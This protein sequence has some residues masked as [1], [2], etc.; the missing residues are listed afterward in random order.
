MTAT[1]IR[2]H[3]G[4][5][6]IYRFCAIIDGEEVEIM[7]IDAHGQFRVR[8]KKVPIDE[9]EGVEVY[10]ALRDFAILSIPDE[11]DDGGE[12]INGRTII[13]N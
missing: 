1:P 8:G 6:Y 3:N 2:D 10:H 13:P 4:E 9:H 7:S 11:D 12:A 5:E